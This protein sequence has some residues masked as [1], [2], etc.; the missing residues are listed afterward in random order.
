MSVRPVVVSLALLALTPSAPA[1]E[2]PPP[3]APPRPAVR[4]YTNEDLDRVHPLRGETGVHSVPAE[5][6]GDAA[7]PAEPKTRGRGEAYWRREAA[8]VRERVLSLETSAAELRARIEEQRDEASQLAGR[9]RRGSASAGGSSLAGMRERL[10]SLER[11]IRH[12]EDDLLDRARRD[13]AL[14]GWLR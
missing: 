11:R 5:A 9:R 1:A 8:R 7:P 3:A 12:A 2:A 6:P 4:V 10:R 13:G 14:P